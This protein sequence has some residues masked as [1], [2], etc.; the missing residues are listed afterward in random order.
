MIYSEIL[1]KNNKK[2]TIVIQIL[3]YGGGILGS[4]HSLANWMEW[5]LG[6]GNWEVVSGKL[7]SRKLG[8]GKLGIGK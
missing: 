5:E 3:V 1:E 4:G 8:S 7:G 2:T 6:I